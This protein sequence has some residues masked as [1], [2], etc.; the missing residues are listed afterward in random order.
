MT[1]K[2]NEIR[3]VTR[4]PIHLLEQQYRTFIIYQDIEFGFG[5]YVFIS[6]DFFSES[7]EPDRLNI[8][9]KTQIS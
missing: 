6:D 3:N 9:K 5:T 8:E 7:V 4:Y 2:T 1:I